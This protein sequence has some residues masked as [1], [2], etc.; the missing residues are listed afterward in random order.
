[1]IPVLLSMRGFLSYQKLTEIDFTAIDVACISGANGAGKSSIFDAI[2]WAIFGVARKTDETIIHAHPEVNAAEV[3]FI[4]EYENNLYRIQRTRPRNATTRLEFQVAQPETVPEP[5][6]KDSLSQI[7][8]RSLTERTYRETQSQIEKILRLNYETF[9]NA[10]FFLQGK[11]DQFTTQNPTNRKKILSSI[12]GLEIWEDYKQRAIERRKAVETQIS[13]IN[14]A[15]QEIESE[16]SEEEARRAKL[17]QLESQLSQIQ[18]QRLEQAERVADYRQQLAALEE[19]KRSSEELH[20]QLTALDKTLQEMTEKRQSRIKERASYQELLQRAAQIEAGYQQYQT[21]QAQLEAFERTFLTFTELEKGFQTLQAELNAERARLE[22][23]QSH[24]LEKQRR[25]VTAQQNRQNYLKELANLQARQESLE[26]ELTL[27]LQAEQEIQNLTQ[28]I[29]DLNG[30]NK[31]LKEE[32]HKLRNR[33]DTL[34]AETVSATCPL[35]GQPLSAADRQKLIASLEEE[36]KGLKEKYLANQSQ[37]NRWEGEKKTL[38]QQSQQRAQIEK[39][40]R[41][42]EGER[43]K[44]TAR[45]TSEEEILQE[46]EQNGA[47]RLQAIQ[48][49]LQLNSFLPDVRE[50]LQEIA[51]Q[52]KALGYDRQAHTQT[53]RAEEEL[54]KVVEEYQSLLQAQAVIPT[55]D[56]EIQELE[57]QQQSLQSQRESLF[58]A[59]QASQAL[60]EQAQKHAP[61]LA[62]A[63]RELTRLE[64]TESELNRQFGAARQLVEVLKDLKKRAEKLQAER[65]EKTTLVARYK[66]LERAFGKDGVP[67]LLIEQA[68]P[69]I[70]ERANQILYRL[71]D[72]KMSLR[73]NTQARY[74]DTRRQDLR[75]TLEIQISDSNGMRDYELFS[76]GEAFRINFAIRLAISELLA[77]RAGARLQTLVIDEGFGSQDAQ[78]RQQLIEAINRVRSEFAK[79]LVISHLDELKDAFPIRLEVEKT[80]QGSVV[81]IV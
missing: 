42:T 32:M 20:K 48:T 75:E 69:Q 19:Q 8:W 16:L 38:Q 1:M 12:L 47:P 45:L 35:C 55:L 72:G 44:W 46:W 13:L 58:Q 50:K 67:A 60:V 78:G 33:I 76:G 81:R 29:T 77:H 30:Q 18:Q 5:L 64:E 74:K 40:L 14:Q 2:T 11:A 54:R 24:L 34:Q 25:A 56:R 17:K 28:Q 53:R 31:H 23:E 49:Q 21:L 36:G 26:A 41:Q 15:L 80:P 68:L 39:S 73:F 52:I 51:Q 43:E 70:E 37:I 4:F 65:T 71:S 63:E 22:Q 57:N 62:A 6:D 79:I 3:A 27:C 61:D 7:R 59:W 10:S 9:I 66:I